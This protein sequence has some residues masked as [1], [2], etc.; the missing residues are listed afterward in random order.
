[1]S[2]RHALAA[3]GLTFNPRRRRLL[4]GVAAMGAASLFPAVSFAQSALQGL[5]R[6]ALV[7]GNSRYQSSPLDNPADDAKA[8]TGELKA[9]GFEVHK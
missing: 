2:T 7:I 9:A 8:I 5:P 6:H 1:M 3:Y 4:E